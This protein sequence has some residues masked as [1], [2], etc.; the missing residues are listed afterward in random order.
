MSAIAQ[1][2]GPDIYGLITFEEEPSRT[3][4]VVRIELKGPPN[5][6]HA[7]HIHSYGD[8]RQGCQSL[9]PHW[10]PHN[11]THGSIFYEDQPRHAGDLINNVYFDSEGCFLLLY[12][13]PLIQVEHIYGRSVVIHSG[14]DDMGR[15]ANAESLETGNAGARLA[16]AIIGRAQ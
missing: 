9:G 13:D 3:Q 11:T 15:G 6:T 12:Y 1:F 14:I 5:S 16:C 7:I 10:N 4:T 2:M 8:L